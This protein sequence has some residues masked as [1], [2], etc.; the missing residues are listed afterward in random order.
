MKYYLLYYLKTFCD[1]QTKL[2]ALRHSFQMDFLIKQSTEWMEL[3][4]R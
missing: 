2:K 1:I 4:V 3:V